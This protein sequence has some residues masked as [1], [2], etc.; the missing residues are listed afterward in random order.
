MTTFGIIAPRLAAKG[1]L[2]VPIRPGTKRPPMNGWPS[3]RLD[4]HALAEYHNCGTGLLCGHLVGVDIDVLHTE[5]AADLHQLARSELGDGPARVGKPPKLLIAYRASAPF[6]KRQTRVFLIDGY[7]CKVEALADGQQFVAFA[8]HPDTKQPYRWLDSNPLDVPFTALP[9]VSEE[10][11]LAFIAKAEAV[12]AKYGVPEKPD[13]PNGGNPTQPV[14][15]GDNDPAKRKAARND[16]LPLTDVA[17]NVGGMAD[18]L[19][20]LV[21]AGGGT[22]TLD[23]LRAARPQWFRGE[24]TLAL[25]ARPLARNLSG[26]FCKARGLEL[27]DGGRLAAFQTYLIG[28]TP[29]MRPLRLSG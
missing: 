4:D 10:R 8:V 1:Y 23:A 7:S 2:P 21:T 17:E 22:V 11:I 24:H 16:S 5:T 14:Q 18:E 19:V 27:G 9:V 28:R 26:D 3:F 6:R 13:Q 12:L 29:T 25:Y 20:A 15:R